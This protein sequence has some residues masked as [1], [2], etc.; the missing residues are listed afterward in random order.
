VRPSLL[1]RPCARRKPADKF[2]R[3]R[4]NFLILRLPARDHIRQRSEDR[5]VNERR[6]D[7]GREITRAEVGAGDR[8][9]QSVNWEAKVSWCFRLYIDRCQSESS[10]KKSKARRSTQ[11][12]IAA[13]RPEG[14][15]FLLRFSWTSVEAGALGASWFRQIRARYSS[16]QKLGGVP[17][18]IVYATWRL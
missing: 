8:L 15:K 17:A 14:F 13:F 12:R 5:F 10:H 3:S 18:K 1:F 16:A 11:R 7:S 9:Y 4:T 6:S 2:R